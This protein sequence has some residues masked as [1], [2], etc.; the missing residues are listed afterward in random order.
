MSVGHQTPERI[1]RRDF[2]RLQ[3]KLDVAAADVIDIV[4][5]TIEAFSASWRD[6]ARETYPP[7]I[8]QWIDTHL[9]H[10]QKQLSR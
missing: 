4:D 2:Q 3:G 1:K 8:A 5:N 10:V 9:T 7:F 6:G